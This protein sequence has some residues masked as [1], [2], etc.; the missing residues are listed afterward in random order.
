MA[1]ITVIAIALLSTILTASCDKRAD[2][3]DPSRSSDL[4]ADPS[5]PPPSEVPTTSAAQVAE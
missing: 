4:A 3:D 2:S 5:V 1:K